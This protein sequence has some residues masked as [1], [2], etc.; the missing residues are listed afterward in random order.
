MRSVSKG[1]EVGKSRNFRSTIRG[2]KVDKS[3]DYR[4]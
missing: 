3:R 2:S 4:R 1:S